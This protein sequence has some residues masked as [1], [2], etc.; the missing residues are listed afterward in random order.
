MIR[1]LRLFLA[2]VFTLP[3]TVAAAQSPHKTA[4]GFTPWPVDFN[5]A[6]L[7]RTYAFIREHANLVAH[8]FDGGIP[9]DPAL[10]ATDLPQHLL[11][12]WQFRRTNTQRGSQV[13]VAV[14]PLNFERNGLATAW[15]N[16]GD[17]QRLPRA[18]RGKALNDPAVKTAY[19]N[20]LRRVI[21]YF[22]P[23]Y[24]A[25]G[26]EANIVISNAPGLWN[27]YLE[28]HTHAY[29]EIKR[30]HPSLSVFVTVQYEHLRGIEGDSKKNLRFQRPGVASLMQHSDLLALSTYQ[31]GT[32]HPNRMTADFLKGLLQ[33]ATRLR[34]AFVVNWVAID[35]DPGLKR[36]PRSVREIAKAWVH[37]GLQ[38]A[39]GADKPALTVWDTYL[40]QSRP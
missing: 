10:N 26:I 5:A 17:N 38:T 37:T 4:M 33:H 31:Y 12:D 24:L 3:A 40:R 13:F 1:A 20:Y 9:W 7:K 6:G 36:L 29:R 22:D 28:L 2:V 34:F 23:D 15:T 25:I 18:W 30:S 8:H 16:K 35:F 32:V 19:V 39:A 21:A 11:R 27:D 14:T